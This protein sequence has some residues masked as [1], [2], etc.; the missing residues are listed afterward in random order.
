MLLRFREYASR[1]HVES[2]L[3]GVCE[4]ACGSAGKANRQAAAKIFFMIS[5]ERESDG[6]PSLPQAGRFP[7]GRLLR[8]RAGILQQAVEP[9]C[10]R[11]RSPV[12]E[13][14]QQMPAPLRERHGFQ[15]SR[16]RPSRA[17]AA[18]MNPGS[19]RSASMAA[20]KRSAIWLA[21]RRRASALFTPATQLPTSLRVE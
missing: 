12:I 5:P 1:S 17:K 21:R 19:S 14:S 7:A 6:N 3:A 20:N 13:E 10:L 18:R 11:I 9:P 2:G 4:A 15:P 16:A 8:V